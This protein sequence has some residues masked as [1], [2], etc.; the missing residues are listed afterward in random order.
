LRKLSLTGCSETVVHGYSDLQLTALLARQRHLISL[1][2][3]LR[4]G[5]TTNSFRIAGQACRGLEHLALR[6]RCYLSELRRARVRPLFPRLRSLASYDWDREESYWTTPQW[7]WVDF[8][9]LLLASHCILPT[10]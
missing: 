3:T 10:S 2:F 5:M 4:S 1:T 7:K 8:V 6:G 9:K